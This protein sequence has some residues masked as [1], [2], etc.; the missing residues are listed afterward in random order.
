MG[1]EAI[2]IIMLNEAEIRAESVGAEHCLRLR[3][4]NFALELCCDSRLCVSAVAGL[5]GRFVVDEVTDHEPAWAR[6]MIL[7]QPDNPWNSPIAIFDGQLHPLGIGDGFNSSKMADCVYHIVCRL[8]AARVNTHFL[9]HAA[10]ISYND[11]GVILAGDSGYGKST[12]TLALV[13]RGCRFLSDEFAALGR[14]DGLL[15]P[16]PRSLQLLPGTLERTGYADIAHTANPWL[17]KLAL[18]VDQLGPDS[19]GSPVPLRHVVILRDPDRIDSGNG[20]SPTFS[21]APRLLPYKIDQAALQT[22]K[23][24]YFGGIGPLLENEYSGDPLKLTMDLINVIRGAGCYE[25]H[26]GHLDQ[27]IDLLWHVFEDQ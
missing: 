27:E 6:L 21:S 19:L 22:L 1:K 26:V 5:L 20:R 17:E 8:I 16:F 24:Y 14:S 13:R 15:Y 10:A 23:H 4:F 11:Q 9:I 2:L 25:L 3:V 18:D 7:T 12:L